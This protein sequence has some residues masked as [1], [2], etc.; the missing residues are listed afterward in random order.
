M[1]LKW[2]V[3][4][5]V[6]LGAMMDE[7]LYQIP[8]ALSGQFRNSTACQSVYK[9]LQEGRL[10]KGKFGR[11][12]TVPSEPVTLL[13]VH[14]TATTSTGRTRK[15]HDYRHRPTTAEWGQSRDFRAGTPE[16]EKSR[17]ETPKWEE[18]R[19][20][21]E[22]PEDR[23]EDFK[24]AFTKR[25]RTTSTTPA[26]EQEGG[27][28]AEIK[29]SDLLAMDR[30]IEEA[31]NDP[32]LHFGPLR[33]NLLYAVPALATAVTAPFYQWVLRRFGT[34]TVC[35]VTYAL[36]FMAVVAMAI[37]SQL[38]ISKALT[39]M[40]VAR[41]VQGIT[42]G[43][44][45]SAALRILSK[46]SVHYEDSLYITGLIL[47]YD[48][49]GA[50]T[51]WITGSLGSRIGLTATLWV[52]VA[53]A[54]ISFVPA[55]ILCVSLRR[56]EKRDQ[57][58]A[59]VQTE[60]FQDSLNW[61]KALSRQNAPASYW[62]LIGFS[63]F[64]VGCIQIFIANAPQMIQDLGYT[65]NQASYAIGLIYFT[66]FLLPIFAF[67]VD[68]WDRKDLWIAVTAGLLLLGFSFMY[69]L[70]SL[71]LLCFFMG[72]AFAMQYILIPACV[73]RS[74]PNA[75]FKS[76]MDCLMA[77]TNAG[78]A[79]LT[80]GTGSVL[81]IFS[82]YLRDAWGKFLLVDTTMAII[83]AIM[84]I[85]VLLF[86]SR[87]GGRMRQRNPEHPRAL[88]MMNDTVGKLNCMGHREPHPPP[89]PRSEPPIAIRPQPTRLVQRPGIQ[90]EHAHIVD[91]PPPPPSYDAAML[92]KEEEKFGILR[93]PAG[94]RSYATIG[95]PGRAL[96]QS[97]R[98][99]STSSRRSQYG[100]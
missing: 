32:C 100:I 51:F 26:E 66:G 91:H 77:V 44:N 45:F 40:L 64:F 33:Y 48:I 62:W 1:G 54:C 25:Y 21:T 17:R 68:Y 31:D 34:A 5:A 67:L 36:S 6:C 29:E 69:L 12:E 97:S 27:E 89:P 85:M 8:A 93:N 41:A 39:T 59:L 38:S 65:E 11:L 92:P 98:S 23:R 15:R 7:Y 80:V 20:T 56:N 47:F 95:R 37:G 19:E 86:D 61:R 30:E 58:A 79:V 28:W 13:P 71:S 55:I 60:I 24:A 4:V 81:Q 14:H 75:S 83:A 43:L 35:V 74:V 72:T 10:R 99:D 88:T 49:G 90:P 42:R 18:F 3:I 78:I 96:S 52:D 50:L 2:T 53:V 84:V 73:A 70:K 87:L 76:A 46:T 9:L 16:R 94:G 82:G 22:D 63:V 57:M